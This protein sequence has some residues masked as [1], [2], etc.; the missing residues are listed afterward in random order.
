VV[1]VPATGDGVA[2]TGTERSGSIAVGRTRCHYNETLLSEF[3]QAMITTTCT[4]SYIHLR[5]AGPR[6]VNRRGSQQTLCRGQHRMRMRHVKL[7]G[8]VA[9]GGPFILCYWQVSN[10]TGCSLGA[11]PSMLRGKRVAIQVGGRCHSL[12]P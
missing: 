2:D 7:S 1:A 8:P 6:R 5:E 12:Q 3:H 9:S 10:H 11:A 4:R